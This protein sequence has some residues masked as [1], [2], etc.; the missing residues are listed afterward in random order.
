MR[1][2]EVGKAF[3]RLLSSES[4]QR[5]EKSETAGWV[6]AKQ[7]MDDDELARFAAE[8]LEAARAG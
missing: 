2:A 4:L 5:P 1:R 6:I 8:I 3:R 7:D